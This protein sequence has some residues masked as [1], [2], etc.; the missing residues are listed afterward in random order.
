MPLHFMLMCPRGEPG[1]HLNMYRVSD[2][3]VQAAGVKRKRITPRD[4]AA[5]YAQ[6]R[7]GNDP[8]SNP[9][10]CCGRGWQ[11]WLCEGYALEEERNL[12]ELRTNK[13]QKNMRRVCF[14]HIRTADAS[15]RGAQLGQRVHL[16]ASFKGGRRYMTACYQDAMALVRRFGRPT[17]FITFTCNPAW[18]EIKRE[19]F[20]SHSA[21]DRPDLTS[22]VFNVKLKELL[23]DLLRGQVLGEVLAHT[24]VVEYQKRGLPHAHILLIMNPDDVPVSAADI[25]AVISAELPDKERC[26]NL[27]ETVTT[28]MLHGPCGPLNPKCPCMRDGVCRNRYPAPEQTETVTGD[29]VH[30]KHR[31]RRDGRTCVKRVL[32]GNTYMDWE[33]DNS[34]VVPYNPWLCTKYNAHINVE[35]ATSVQSVKYLYKYIYKGQDRALAELRRGREPDSDFAVDEIMEYIDGRYI[36]A[37]EAAWRTFGFDTSAVKP[38]VQRLDLHLPGEEL[39]TV[40]AD[41]L[42]AERAGNGPPTTTLN[43]YFAYNRAHRGEKPNA[44]LVYQDFPEHF[45]FSAKTGWSPRRT[46]AVAI[47]RVFSASIRDV[48]RFN[49]RVLLNHVK[50][51]TSFEDL[52]TY[53][54][55]V[56][57]TFKEAAAARGL[58]AD[59]AEWD[60]ALQEASLVA[61][62]HNIRSLF[63]MILEFETVADASTLWDKH[64]A[65]LCEDYRRAAQRTHPD[66]PLDVTA[67]EN[68]GLI[69]MHKLL[70]HLNRPLS[71]YGLPDPDLTVADMAATEECDLLAQL[72]N[73]DPVQMRA[74]VEARLGAANACQR[75]AYHAVKVA[76]DQVLEEAAAAG[77]G[78]AP[79]ARSAS[80]RLAAPRVFF[81]TGAAGTGKTFVYDALLAYV[82]G[83]GHIA[84]ATATSGIAALLLPGG[85]TTHSAFKIPVDELTAESQCC[86]KLTQPLTPVVQAVAQAALLLIDEGP[87]M[88][89]HAF[90]A[91]DKSLR[92]IMGVDEPFGGKVIVVGGDFRQCLP[93]VRRAQPGQIV[94][95]SLKRSYLWPEFKKLSLTINER[96]RRASMGATPETARAAA[97][98]AAYI[99]RVGDG[100]EPTFPLD[101]GS[102]ADCV[103]L[104]RS[105]VVPEDTTVDGLVRL[106]Y[107]DNT[108]SGSAFSSTEADHLFD[109]T[110]LAPRNKDVDAVNDA[111]LKLFPAAAATANSPAERTYYSYDKVDEEEDGTQYQTEV[112]NAVKLGGLPHHELKLKKGAIVMLLRNLCPRDGL[113]NGTRL[114]VQHMY[115]H[116]LEAR[117]VGGIHHGKVCLI[118][119]ITCNSSEADTGFKLQRRQFPVKLAFGMTIN[120]SQGQTL[121]NVVVYLPHPVFAHGQL[122][123]ALS[124][125]GDPRHIKILVKNGRRADAW[126]YTA[127][128]VHKQVVQRE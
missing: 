50:G 73:Y 51:P 98:Y 121:H 31:R 62:P 68:R 8:D 116:L 24:Y 33:A 44:E 27:W 65:A 96:V 35:I 78:H 29:G 9:L 104:P 56:Y 94:Q 61:F 34:V 41:E 125:V 91:I 117:V 108:E 42:V 49:L 128:V 93:V 30:I 11:E 106:V 25:D 47:G 37:C 105:M 46:R 67:V 102:Q 28:C 10:H 83:R 32:V 110:I 126:T 107:G 43:A 60:A 1:W 88:N 48:E 39:C 26:P 76:V 14:D 85:T 64:K 55:V 115:K 90:G 120:K 122:Y 77:E 17:Y 52:R 4:F 40:E 123:T 89:K 19:L 63:A 38:P 72:R 84:L 81:L 71:Y 124:R 16:P 80:V 15:L 74:V 113:A 103:R 127:N 66:A 6:V 86:L 18:E 59:D 3:G 92:D 87:M 58:M 82:R 7:G 20:P 12:Q 112:L 79:T 69:A 22:R 2:P 101:D 36:G 97:E 53:G 57:G 119:R 114:I 100:D 109:R 13:R 70:A 5:Y 21:V 23:N 54:G 99:L 75:S 111:A 45:T 95:L 118:P